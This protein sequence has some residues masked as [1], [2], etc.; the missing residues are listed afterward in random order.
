MT[1]PVDL[2]RIDRRKLLQLAAAGLL[3]GN[4]RILDAQACDNTH[5]GDAA[6]SKPYTAQFFTAEEIAVL[7]RVMEAIL[8]ADDHS[9]GAHA[10]QVPLFADLIVANS[11][12]DVKADWRSG[13][14]LLAAELKTS[15]LDDWLARTAEN[16]R[17]PRTVLDLFFAKLKQMT[18]EGYY[19]SRIGIHQD[20]RYQGNT[21]QTEFKGC[22]H[23]EHQ[24]QA[25][26]V[27]GV[28]RG[29]GSAAAMPDQA[30]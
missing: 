26:G 5:H 18:V 13:L 2:S 20:L 16:E 11:P 4:F 9:P 15:S 19:T 22:T 10:A 23:A 7:D 3:A 24:T 29:G 21:Y 25:R 30:S 12:A 6:E 17:N 14:Q 8:P 28:A 1:Q 27:L